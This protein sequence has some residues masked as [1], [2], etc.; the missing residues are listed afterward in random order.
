[1]HEIIGWIG[2]IFYISAYLLL[3]IKKLKADKPLYQILNVLG[4]G[5]LIVNSLHQQ[6]YPSIFVNAAWAMIGMFAIFYNR[7]K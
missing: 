3:S 5:C 7:N 4:G 6:D 2:T 1:M